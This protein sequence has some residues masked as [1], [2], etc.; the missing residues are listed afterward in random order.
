MSCNENIVSAVTTNFIKGGIM[1]KKF[2]KSTALL[3]II[4]L[5]GCLL[6]TG[7]GKKGPPV[8]PYSRSK[9]K[10]VKDLQIHMHEDV[11]NL[12]WTVP[13]KEYEEMPKLS[14]FIVYRSREPLEKKECKG[15]PIRYKAVADIPLVS[16]APGDRMLYRERVLKGYRYY[17][18]VRSY[19]ENGMKSRRSDTVRI[20]Y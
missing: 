12:V 5:A 13:K 2:I 11:L 16:K 9:P 3:I 17:F 6:L 4:L 8:P 19:Y 7:C 14:G 1:E 15:C 20:A 18:S 10:A